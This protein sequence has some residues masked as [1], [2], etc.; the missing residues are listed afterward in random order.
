MISLYFI[1]VRLGYYVNNELPEDANAPPSAGFDN[2]ILNKTNEE[3][4]A[5][6]NSALFALDNA[7]ATSTNAA[8]GGATNSNAVALAT[9]S[10]SATNATSSSAV[11]ELHNPDAATT[12]EANDDDDEDEDMAANEGEDM[13]EDENTAV[14]GIEEGIVSGCVSLFARRFRTPACRDR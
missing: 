8:S 14:E 12:N 13:D 4:N 5:S 2:S 9:N 11:A 7:A 1:V 6:A 10:S 3:L